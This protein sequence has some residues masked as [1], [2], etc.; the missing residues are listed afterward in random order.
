[1]ISL[2]SKQIKAF[3]KHKLGI[4]GLG[5]VFT[6]VLIA[7]GADLIAPVDPNLQNLDKKFI[8]PFWDA[9][10]QWTHLLGTDVLGRDMFAR[11]V[12]GARLSIVI[13]SLAVFTGAIVGIPMGMIAG[14]FGGKIDMLLMR[15]IDIMLAFPSL[16]LAVCIV[17]IL[18]PSLENAV[19]AI[20]IVTIPTYAR[21]SRASVLSEKEKEYV[22][23]DIALGRSHTAILMK[24]IL[25]N[26]VSPL[27]IL[28]TLGFGGAVLDAAGLSFLGLG[29][30][31]PT[32][33]WGALITEG[34]KYIFQ[35]WWLII[36]PGLAILLTV[37][38]FNLF[39]DAI[40]DVFDPKSNKN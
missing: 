13:G 10:G 6:L 37:V 23:A 8:P 40:R 33:E 32:P 27:F 2:D 36:F 38:G 21:V 29:A 31:P 39:G 18:G 3:K 5:I 19:L 17:A 4:F 28:A 11:I 25:P 9:A 16:L 34:K 22:L 12:Y 15:T 7:I 26:I 20:G 35:A 14:Y 24:G 30:Q 1:M